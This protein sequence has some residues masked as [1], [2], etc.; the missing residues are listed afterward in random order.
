MDRNGY[1]PATAE[2]RF[3][4]M[5]RFRKYTAGLLLLVLV[6]GV[7]ACGNSDNNGGTNK[8]NTENNGTTNVFKA[9]SI[10]ETTGFEPTTFALRTQRSP[11]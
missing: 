4:I 5:K 1:R 7:S 11:S 9:F 3:Y 2:R 10:M 8:P 6:L